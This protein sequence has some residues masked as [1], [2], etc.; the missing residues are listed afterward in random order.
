M[1]YPHDTRKYTVSLGIIRGEP[2]LLSRKLN[3]PLSQK[4]IFS[5]FT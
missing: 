5:F 3:F 2:A 1:L 4:K